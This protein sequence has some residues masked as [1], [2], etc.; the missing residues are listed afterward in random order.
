MLIKQIVTDS[1]VLSFATLLVFPDFMEEILKAKLN[2]QQAAASPSQATAA[3]SCVAAA[4][5]AIC[6]RGVA[7]IGQVKR[8]GGSLPL[9][10]CPLPNTKK[11]CFGI[12]FEKVGEG[13]KILQSAKKSWNVQ[14]AAISGHMQFAGTSGHV[15][16][17]V[18]SSV[19]VAAVTTGH[20]EAAA[21]LCE[22]EHCILNICAVKHLGLKPQTKVC[23][24]AA[25]RQDSL[26]WSRSVAAMEKNVKMCLAESTARKYD[27]WWSRFNEFCQKTEA[28]KMPFSGHTAAV[29]L[30]HIAESAVG[31][32]GA[33]AARSALRH[34]FLVH[35][36]ASKCPTDGPEVTL[37]MKGIHRRFE[38]PV[39]K[40][41]P[42]TSVEFYK[43][44]TFLTDKASFKKVRLCQLRLAAQI[45]LMFLAFSRFEESSA[46]KRSQV[47]KC[48]EDLAVNFLKGKN[49][50]YGEARRSVI[51]SQPG[52]L[53][54][55]RV[56]LAYMV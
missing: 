51:A 1:L 17:A 3:S 33:D 8:K 22:D 37:V 19:V 32:G 40:K 36:P 10:S 42:L 13:G 47:V 21:K 4:D 15:K 7:K 46:L 56:I 54:P 44:L 53:N 52:L 27:Y 48:Q 34:F 12:L 45:S 30:S 11:I 26:L 16:T 43:L 55:V 18:K 20:G 35:C 14:S 39:V 5:S 2:W 28:V 6:A 50:Q 41:A 31:L 29:F 24:A 49:F 38:K 9:A 25:V 23:E